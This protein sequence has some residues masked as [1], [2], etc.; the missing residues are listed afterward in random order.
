ML[1][2]FTSPGVPGCCRAVVYLVFMV[3]K[4]SDEAERD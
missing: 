3:G 2:L 4:I 1:T